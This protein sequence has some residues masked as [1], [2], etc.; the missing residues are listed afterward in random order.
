[1]DIDV[2]FAQSLLRPLP[3]RL[4]SEFFGYLYKILL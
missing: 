3:S 2:G 4:T 1:M